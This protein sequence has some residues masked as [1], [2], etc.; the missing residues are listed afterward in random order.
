MERIAATTDRI[1]VMSACA[2]DRLCRDYGVERHKVVTIPHGGTV[3]SGPRLKRPSRPT[4]LTWGMLAPGKGVEKVIDVM[5]SL[6]GLA[7]RPRY[8][9]VGPTDLGKQ[10]STVMNT[11]RR[12]S[13]RPAPTGS[14][15]PCPS[16]PART[17]VRR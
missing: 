4:I 3:F 14:Q 10:P 15:T 17:T 6:Q 16:M 5:S 8:V 12:A 9:V 13:S 1:V 11:G 2:R 7:G